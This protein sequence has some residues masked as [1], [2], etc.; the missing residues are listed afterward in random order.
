M[1]F[2]ALIPLMDP[3]EEHGLFLRLKRGDGAAF[4]A[5]YAHYRPRLFGFL[6]RLCGRRDVAED[7]LQETWLRLARA[8]PGLTEDSRVGA[9][10][11]AVAR[12]LFYSERRRAAWERG[13]FLPAL[14]DERTA[15]G[16]PSPFDLTAASETERVLESAL[17]RLPLEAREVLLLVAVERLTPAEAAEVLGVKP[18]ALRQRLSRARGALGAALQRTER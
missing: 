7:L 15:D 10:L 6:A 2:Q 4:D 12:N 13:R 14:P 8:A 9:W 17:A 16:A 18:E 11:F 5:L 1:G 3:V